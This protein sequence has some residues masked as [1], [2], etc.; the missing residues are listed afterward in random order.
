M[1][2]QFTSRILSTVK[3]PVILRFPKIIQRVYVFYNIMTEEVLLNSVHQNSAVS[4]TVHKEVHSTNQ[5]RQASTS[6]CSLAGGEVLD[7]PWVL[8]ST[9]R[10]AHLSFEKSCLS[11]S[12]NPTSSL[13]TDSTALTTHWLLF[14]NVIQVK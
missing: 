7:Q 6:G 1:Y 9:K 8:S 4:E 2:I 14:Q 11:R 10:H 5:G 12:T 13:G 3:F